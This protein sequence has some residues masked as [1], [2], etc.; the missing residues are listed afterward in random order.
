MPEKVKSEKKQTGTAK[1]E[2]KSAETAEKQAKKGSSSLSG[3]R[4]RFLDLAA[5]AG[6]SIEGAVKT[7]LHAR[8]NVIMARVKEDHLKKIDSLVEAG[9]FKSR[10][11]SVAF[12]ISEG[13]KAR[14]DLYAVIQEKTDEIEKLRSQLRDM[15][16]GKTPKHK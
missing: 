4:E 6:Q 13:I 9:I 7:A 12:L 11:E 14:Q 1:K 3:I 16:A 8:A 2:S 15:L 5:E 10:S